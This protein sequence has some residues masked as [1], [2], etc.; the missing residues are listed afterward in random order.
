MDA[1][2]SLLSTHLWSWNILLYTALLTS[3]IHVVVLV[4]ES[5]LTPCDPT[6]CS[7]AGS[8]LHRILQARILEWVVIS[9]S[10][11]SSGPRNRTR[12]S[13]IVRQVL[14]HLSHWRSPHEL[15][16]MLKKR[17]YRISL[18]VQWLK[19]CTPNA[20]DTGLI[21]DQGRPPMPH[22]ATKKKK[23]TTRKN[24]IF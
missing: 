6:D 5:C 15:I 8:S 24:K 17:K 18:A 7:S 10:R 14:Y 16:D 1:E 4:A 2:E 9:F 13:C 22:S 11:G 19:L 20:G 12:I 21:P 23:S 3:W